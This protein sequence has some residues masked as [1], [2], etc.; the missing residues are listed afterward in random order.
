M[1]GGSL[2]GEELH[3]LVA[4]LLVLHDEE[5]VV[6]RRIETLVRR[7]SLGDAPEQ[8]EQGVSPA[9]SAP[10]GG[11]ADSA[12]GG[13]KDEASPGSR[14][15][16]DRLV[17][18]ALSRAFSSGI[19]GGEVDEDDEVDEDGGEAGSGEA[20]DRARHEAGEERR[21]P[22]R[23]E[24]HRPP[25]DRRDEADPS[26]IPLLLL[27][28]GQGWVGIPW[29][30]VTR[31]SLDEEDRVLPLGSGREEISEEEPQ[32]G[33]HSLFALLRG[34][35]K[36]G[37]AEPYRVLW[38]TASGTEGMA[39]AELGD[40]V[41]AS[42][43]GERGIEA[44]LVLDPGKAGPP[45][46]VTLLDFLARPELYMPALPRRQA[47]PASREAA[48]AEPI[49]EETSVSPPPAGSELRAPLPRGVLLAVHYLPARVAIGRVL[50]SRGWTVIEAVDAREITPKLRSASYAA[51]FVEAPEM[52]APEMISLLQSLLATGCPVVAVASRLRGTGSDPL[53]T[54][55]E[56]P[57]LLYPFQEVDLERV[58]E[59]LR[60][61]PVRS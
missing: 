39:C 12:T 35:P 43:A 36:P 49:R 9:P 42:V 30:Q 34:A 3:A 24:E 17:E 45:S 27:G 29:T 6:L 53:R 60:W 18:K 44:V 38:E 56:I 50:R 10:S 2:R 21:L 4:R 15:W 55:G 31:I 52:P 28:D 20:R 1:N 33:L 19:H 26:G 25:D 37:P 23:G 57:R 47:K 54:L 11:R 59:I 58:L 32:P 22:A 48:G 46:P 40:V 8:Q 51:V 14:A 16:V 13:E 5:L 61:V 41:S 7:D